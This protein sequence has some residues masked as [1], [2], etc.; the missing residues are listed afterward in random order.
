M[1]SAMASL[2]A[3]MSSEKNVGTGPAVSSPLNSLDSAGHAATAMVGTLS[4]KN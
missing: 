1:L 4:L 3:S 2:A